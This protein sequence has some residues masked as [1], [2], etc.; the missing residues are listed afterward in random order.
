[1]NKVDESDIFTPRFDANG[2]IPCM[3]ISHEDQTPL[4]L[5]YMNEDAL[6]LTLRTGEMHY[7][8]RSR[9]EIWH[10][11]ATSGHV[12]KLVDMRVD[13]DQDCLVAIVQMDPEIACHTGR[14]GCFYRRV[15][16]TQDVKGD[17]GTLEFLED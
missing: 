16:S 15:L 17:R 2:L 1:M 9:Q 4:M 14:R 10:K 13:C 7:W 5:A 6:N 8:S 3:A 11:G 12:Q